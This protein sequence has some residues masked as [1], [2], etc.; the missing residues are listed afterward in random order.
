MGEQLQDQLTVAAS[1]SLVPGRAALPFF[2]FLLWQDVSL[3][4]AKSSQPGYNK[5]LLVL[6]VGRRIW[7]WNDPEVN[8][9][10][11]PESKSSQWKTVLQQRL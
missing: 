6:A 7:S 5:L 1:L 4:M 3:N 2:V 9:V 8:C 10:P 11:N